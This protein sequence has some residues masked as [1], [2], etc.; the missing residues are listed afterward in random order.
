MS[1][2]LDRLLPQIFII[3]FSVYILGSDDE[4]DNEDMIGE[5]DGG[6]GNDDGTTSPTAQR[7]DQSEEG[8]DSE[9]DESKENVDEEEDDEDLSDGE[10]E[11]EDDGDDAAESTNEV[12]LKGEMGMQY[13]VN[14]DSSTVLCVSL[15]TRTHWKALTQQLSST[16][17]HKGCL[18]PLEN[19]TSRISCKNS[20][21]F[22]CHTRVLRG[23]V[24]GTPTP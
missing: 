15:P 7:N 2:L 17:A 8:S 4:D 13:Y 6:E 24:F 10:D 18:V 5:D 16:L 19:F 12:N 22:T 3:I 9:E 11:Q 1:I 23:K 20:Q 21:N 14:D